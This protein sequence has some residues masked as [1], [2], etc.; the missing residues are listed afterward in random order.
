MSPNVIIIGIIIVIVLI[1]IYKSYNKPP[2]KQTKKKKQTTHNESKITDII[3]N[4]YDKLHPYWL[5]NPNLTVE[6]Y[7]RIAKPFSEKHKRIHVDDISFIELQ[8]AY[9]EPNTV[10]TKTYK[11]ILIQ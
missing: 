11:A 5:Q 2:K 4:L 8:Q 6:D 10:T 7:F 9:E 3:D 1:L